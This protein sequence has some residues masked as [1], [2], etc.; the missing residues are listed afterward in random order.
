MAI[1]APTHVEPGKWLGYR[2]ATDL[3]M[4][5]LAIQA[6]G[7]VWSVIEIDK[8]RLDKHRHPLDGFIVGDC[9]GKF[10]LLLVFDG[11]LLVATPAFCLGRYTCGGGLP[12]TRMTIEALHTKANMHTVVKLDG[13]FGWL[14]CIPD[15]VTGSTQEEEHYYSNYHQE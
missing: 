3:A 14:L 4:A 6:G 8:I 7:N 10:L 2:L 12:C 9:V 1:Q 15:A 5:G 11:N 13:L